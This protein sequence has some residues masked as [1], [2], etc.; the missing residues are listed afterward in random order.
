M[1]YISNGKRKYIWFTR[2]GKEQFFN[3]EKDPHE[4]NNL[5]Q[6]QEFS[7]ELSYFR[8]SLINELSKRNCGIV[9]KNKLVVQSKSMISSFR[10]KLF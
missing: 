8:Q 10:D 5:T 2:T 1:Q 3:L 7:D 4:Q 6:K 9:E